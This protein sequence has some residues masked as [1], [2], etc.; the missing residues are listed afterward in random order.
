VYNRQRDVSVSLPWFRSKASL[1]AAYLRAKSQAIGIYFVTR[2]EI[3]EL[4]QR[5]FNDPTIT[6]CITLPI[7]EDSYWGDIFIC[8]WVA[9][10][11]AEQHRL[12]VQDEILLYMIH[13]MLHLAGY[14]DQTPKERA[15]MRKKEKACMKL[16]R[17]AE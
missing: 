10:E 2:K 11:Y 7:L 5:H 3:A 6:D 9:K 17:D 15:R 8:P 1:V 13:G 16:C 12:E 14:D 4:H